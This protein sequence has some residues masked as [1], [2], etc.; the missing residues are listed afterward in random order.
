MMNDFKMRVISALVST[1]CLNVIQNPPH[2][3]KG[4]LHCPFKST[5]S[6]HLCAALLLCLHTTAWLLLR[7]SV[8]VKK[9]KDSL[10]K[11]QPGG[12][13][14]ATVAMPPRVVPPHPP[15]VCIPLCTT[16][17]CCLPP[18]SSCFLLQSMMGAT[19]AVSPLSCEP[20]RGEGGEETSDAGRGGKEEELVW[21][22][23]TMVTAF[24]QNLCFYPLMLKEK[25]NTLH[26]YPITFI[27]FSFNMNTYSNLFGNF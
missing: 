13:L 15:S 21:M 25:L 12:V 6:I 4:L 20:C 26:I 27:Q 16:L 19:N 7:F 1:F 18:A 23:I 10:R 11:Q 9:K 5:G 8:Q 24:L 14:E 3:L 22:R 17:C 2:H